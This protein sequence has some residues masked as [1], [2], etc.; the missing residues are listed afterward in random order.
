M[1]T[2]RDEVPTGYKKIRHVLSGEERGRVQ[3]NLDVTNKEKLADEKYNIY[4]GMF[5]H[6]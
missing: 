1:F 5:V 4:T 3:Q 6:Q 2:T